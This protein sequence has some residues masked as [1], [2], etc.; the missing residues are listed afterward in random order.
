MAPANGSAQRPPLLLRPQYVV[1]P[2]GGRRMETELGREDLPDGPVGESWEATDL[3][4]AVSIIE[5]G[6]HHG[7]PL[8][9]VLGATF[10][11]LLKILDAREDLS[12]QVHPDGVDGGAFKDEAWVALADGGH[13][14]TGR[15]DGDAPA[16]W[17]DVLERRALHAGSGDGAVRPSMVHVP[18]GTVHAI[19]AGSLVFEVQNPVDITW[20]LDDYGRPGV[21]GQP[22]QLHLEEAS[23]VLARGPRPAGALKDDGRTLDSD[24]FTLSLLPPGRSRG[25]GALAAFFLAEGDVHWREGAFRVPRA[26]TVVLP[27][28]GVRLESDGWIVACAPRA[29]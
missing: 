1:K 22:R 2:W 21:D 9:D 27:P 4:G 6:P 5:G 15:Q 14:A 19:L 11:L 8:P 25:V 12:V 20:R 23:A 10:P 17:L 26:R 28:G 13:V 18:P 16:R 29:G 24:S 3:P 7:L